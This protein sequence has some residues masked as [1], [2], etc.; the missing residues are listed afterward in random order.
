MNCGHTVTFTVH[1]HFKGCDCTCVSIV[2]CVINYYCK[3]L[4]SLQIQNLRQLSFK[5]QNCFVTPTVQN[6]V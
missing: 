6:L 1:V 4:S 5:N 2:V 3:A